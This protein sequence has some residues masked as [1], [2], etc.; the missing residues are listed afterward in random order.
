MR[1]QLQPQP[2]E[3]AVHDAARSHLLL[4]VRPTAVLPVCVLLA[5]WPRERE[6]RGRG[7]SLFKRRFLTG[8]DEDV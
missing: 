5:F 2:P 1:Q 4:A 7:P 8:S 6:G 3:G